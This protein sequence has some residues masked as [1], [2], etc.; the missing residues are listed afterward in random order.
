MPHVLTPFFFPSL[1]SPHPNPS[2]MEEG[3]KYSM[4]MNKPLL[5]QEKGFGDEVDLS[6]RE[7]KR[8]SLYGQ[9]GG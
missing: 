1:Y 7:K 8:V 3:L 2:P 5:F 9:E 6:E 4:S